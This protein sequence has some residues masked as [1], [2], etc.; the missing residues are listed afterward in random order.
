M[1]TGAAV[2]WRLLVIAIAIWATVWGLA[3]LYLVTMP[4]IIALILATILVP[5]AG[6][7]ETKGW[8]RSMASLVVVGGGLVAVLGLLAALAPSFVE[9]LRD[10]AP[11][12]SLGS[13]TVLSWLETGP[14]HVPRET[15][16][17]LISQVRDALGNNSSTIVGGVLTGAALLVETLAAL[18]LML[19]LLFFVIKDRDEIVTWLQSH[20]PMA[21]RPRVGAMG[22]RAWSALGGYVRGT[23]VIALIDAGGIGIG[24]AILGV[25]LALPLT[26]L[27]FLGGFLPIIGAFA[28]G[29]VAVLVAL[30]TG[31]LTK[32]LLAL[33]LILAVQQLEG[34]ILQ[35]VIMRRAVNLH[36]VV[37]LIALAT[38]A[39]IAGIAGAFLSIPVAAV[40]A[41]VG[42]EALVQGRTVADR[43]PAQ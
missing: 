24:L 26:L 12:L 25:P 1:D 34:H 19:V 41:A 10:L 35:P 8:R 43:Q 38:G 28:A 18:A 2:S 15:V 14:L 5:V 7:L 4:I 36:P 21:D 6:W 23:A 13:D 40:V 32:A 11:T 37:I 31:G 22:A 27:V 42:N 30:A 16:D 17:D 3:R 33:G 29:M 20:V 39:S 9:Q